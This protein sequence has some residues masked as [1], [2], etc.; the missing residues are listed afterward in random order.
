MIN[1]NNCRQN[2][3]NSSSLRKFII[4]QG[5]D[6]F[7]SFIIFYKTYGSGCF[8]LGSGKVEI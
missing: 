6:N 5:V 1:V 7:F 8:S 2:L 3:K 4:S